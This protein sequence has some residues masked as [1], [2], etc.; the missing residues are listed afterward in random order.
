MTVL[1]KNDAAGASVLIKDAESLSPYEYGIEYSSPAR[2]PWNIV[3]I[4]MLLP[5]SHQIYVCAQACMRGVVLTAAEMNAMDRFSSIAI[6]ENNLLDG[7]MEQLIVDG[8]T[9]IINKLP[10]RPRAVMIFTTCV[11]HFLA[12]DLGF[13]FT[14]LRE[15]FPN[16]DF[17]DCY[18]HPIMRKTKTAPDPKMREQLYSFLKAMPADP[19]SINIIGNNEKMSE[20]S[21]LLKMI[22]A[23]GYKIKDIC[24]C[25]SYDEYQEMAASTY[26]ITINP[27]ATVAADTLEKRLKQKQIYLPLSYDYDEIE[28]LLEKAAGILSLQMP[29]IDKIHS[30]AESEI[31]ATKDAIEDT[32]IAIDYTATTRP[33]GLAKLLIEHGFNVTSV[34]AD[35]FTEEERSAFDWLKKNA[36]YLRLFATV[37][38]K[39]GLLPH[40]AAKL[41]N[42]HL[43]AIGQKSAYFTGTSYFVNILEGGGLWGYDGICQLMR[44]MREAA[45]TPK[46]TRSI[47]QVKGWG[48]CC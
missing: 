40:D 19:A 15:K 39:M 13:V 17:T 20:T 14:Q 1:C 12:C 44:L 29:D 36:G 7:D 28:K 6:R 42:G 37:H 16:I 48:C 27:A 24:S 47:I 34:Y 22:R 21:E 11:H 31:K 38:P 4:G 43:L 8:V 10:K 30:D 2:G 3:H 23:A 32:P 35:T 25:K 26:N 46:D 41:N 5:E 33:L 45:K 18:M 9:D